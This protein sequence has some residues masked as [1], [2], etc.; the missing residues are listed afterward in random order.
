MLPAN[1]SRPPIHKMIA[2]PATTINNTKPDSAARRRTRDK[3]A[4]RACCRRLSNRDNTC[5]LCAKAITVRIPLRLSSASADTSPSASCAAREAA[6][7]RRANS[8][9]GMTTTGTTAAT[10]TDI[11]AEDK[12]TSTK[13]PTSRM[14]LR[15]AIETVEAR[16]VCTTAVSAFRRARTSP[17]L[18]VSNQCRGRLST[19]ANRARRIEAITCS[20][21]WFKIDIRR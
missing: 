14:T 17:V 19:C 15:T 3:A 9:S 10:T 16:T 21:T 18:A 13:P 6:R 2:T 11:F 20:A 1:R 5:G 8:T 4:A 7:R 12:T